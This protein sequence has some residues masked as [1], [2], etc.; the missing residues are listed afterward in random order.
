M[1]SWFHAFIQHLQHGI[2]FPPPSRSCSHLPFV[3]HSFSFFFL[4]W[5]LLRPYGFSETPC[6]LCVNLFV[7]SNLSL[8]GLGFS[9]RLSAFSL[10][11]GPPPFFPTTRVAEAG[12][13]TSHGFRP[14][15]LE[16]RTPVRINFPFA[17]A[18][19]SFS[20]LR[21]RFPLASPFLFPGAF[22]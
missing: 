21:T 2:L 15:H 19:G 12:G 9:F 3:M 14:A 22:S 8:P 18:V 5:F 13:S 4:I 1:K 10:P 11:G 6:S 17:A 20:L 7:D 16:D